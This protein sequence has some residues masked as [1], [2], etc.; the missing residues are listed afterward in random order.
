MAVDTEEVNPANETTRPQ[1]YGSVSDALVDLAARART[2]VV[3]VR[4]RGRG[5]GSGVVWAADG[6]VLTNHHVVVACRWLSMSI[7]AK[8]NVLVQQAATNT[9]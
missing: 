3:E 8:I 5:A 2:G 7:S 4:G 1:T 9:F 6:R